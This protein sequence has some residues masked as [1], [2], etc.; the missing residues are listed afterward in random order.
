MGRV[1]HG[2]SARMGHST[3]ETIKSGRRHALL[4]QG[5]DTCIPKYEY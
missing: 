4:T 3:I 2:E 5:D 1:H